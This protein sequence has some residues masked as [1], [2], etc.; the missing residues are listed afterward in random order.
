MEIILRKKNLFTQFSSINPDRQANAIY[1][2]IVT[3]IT[4]QFILEIYRMNSI[5]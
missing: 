2:L 3:V 1:T 5:Y 4:Y